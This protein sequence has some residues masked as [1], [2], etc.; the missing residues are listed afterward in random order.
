M[1]VYYSHVEEEQ[2]EKYI[3]LLTPPPP[4]THTDMYKCVYSRETLDAAAV[5][6]K[7]FNLLY[8]L[9]SLAPN[10]QHRPLHKHLEA[11]TR[12]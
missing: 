11:L 6:N 1:C 7:V 3:P 8:W 12:V 5:C 2:I 4:P 9:G 10:R